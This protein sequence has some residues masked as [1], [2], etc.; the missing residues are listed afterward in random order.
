VFSIAIGIIKLVRGSAI[1]ACGL[2]IYCCRPKRLTGS[3]MWGLIEHH[4]GWKNHRIIPQFGASLGPDHEIF[5]RPKQKSRI[6]L[7]RLFAFLV[8]L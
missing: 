2:I 3:K 5:N 7:T 8:W 1:M 4:A 6:K